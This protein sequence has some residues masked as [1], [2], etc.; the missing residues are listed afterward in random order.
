MDIIERKDFRYLKAIVGIAFLAL[1]PFLFTNDYHRLLVNKVFI[2]AI[3]VMGLNFITGLVG[4]MNT[5]TA[6]MFALGAY[7]A[8]LLTTKLGVSLNG[9]DLWL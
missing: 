1:L 2:Y 7:T 8:A 6:G 5:G 9:Q 3:V 4:Q